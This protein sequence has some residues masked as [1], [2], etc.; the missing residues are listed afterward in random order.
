MDITA[1]SLEVDIEWFNFRKLTTLTF[2]GGVINLFVSFLIINF[3]STTVALIG[4]K[5]VDVTT[6][7]RSDNT[8]P[9]VICVGLKFGAGSLYRS[10]LI[11]I[12]EGSLQ[13]IGFLGSK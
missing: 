7:K 1:F 5:R 9:F 4:I 2:K 8:E 3:G 10:R 13:S 6:L 11:M 12:E